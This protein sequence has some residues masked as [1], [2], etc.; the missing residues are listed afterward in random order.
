MISGSFNVLSAGAGAF[1][2]PGLFRGAVVCFVE[3]PF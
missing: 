2:K 3:M 1:V